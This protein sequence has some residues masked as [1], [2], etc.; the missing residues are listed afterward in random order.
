MLTDLQKQNQILRRLR[1]KKAKSI[2]T[3][4]KQEW[5]CMLKEFPYCVKCK[6]TNIILYKDHIIPIY[7]TERNPSDSIEN[8]QP[9][10]K[11][12]NSS[13]SGDSTNYIKIIKN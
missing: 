4:T 5:L 1:I 3:H 9:L 2:K 10:C 11:S 12:C 8:I 13:K 6:K 7:Q